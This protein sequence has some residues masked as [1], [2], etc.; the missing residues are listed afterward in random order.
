LRTEDG[1]VTWIAQAPFPPGDGW[2]DQ[3]ITVVD[4]QRAVAYQYGVI[5]STQDGGL[6]WVRSQM[7]SSV[8]VTE[9]G[10][11][12]GIGSYD[13]HKLPLGATE[14]QVVFRSGNER[15]VRTASMGSETDGLLVEY[16]WSTSTAVWNRTS[17]GGRTWSTFVPAGLP[18]E[19]PYWLKLTGSGHAWTAVNGT[20][21]RSVDAGASWATVALPADASYWSVSDVTIHDERTL[22]FPHETGYYLSTDAGAHWTLLQV[23]GDSDW[24]GE[25]RLWL[26]GGMQWLVRNDRVHVTTDMGM[27]WRQA[28]GPAADEVEGAMAAVWFF[29]A[30]KGM[31]VSS[32]G[33][34]LET[35]DGGRTWQRRALA[36]GSYTAPRLQFA[37]RSV[38][39]M[40]G[41]GGI[42]K[43][44]DGGASWWLPVT[45]TDMH[46]IS[47][48]HFAD[49]EHG[50]AIVNG[51]TVVQTVDGGGNWQEKFSSPYGM[52]AI[53]FIDSDVG[54]MVGSS[55]AI[56]RTV[57]G[58]ATW[59][60]RASDTT[61]QLL[62]VTFVDAQHGWAVGDD[63]AVVQTGDGGLSWQSVPVPQLFGRSSALRDVRFADRLHGWIVG[64]DG[65]MLAT[66]DGGQTWA[67]QDSGTSHSLHGAFALDPYTAWA[68]GESS[69]VLATVTAGQ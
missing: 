68:V 52:H 28:F 65:T 26:Q 32:A 69:T 40:S 62:R 18:S 22:G 42:S 2:S 15:Y 14:S 54:V 48:F 23:P 13:V 5:A 35:T 33:W 45:D 24:Y 8:T 21:F 37:S 55:G 58:G 67:L 34:L 36:T 39:W 12:W 6:T 29:D 60:L 53:H 11:A 16:E 7:W 10:T 27:S 56:M 20:L 66:R 38:G 9:H 1:G 3:R 59:S 43:T 51:Y 44:T 25:L 41:A 49:D 63:S 19:T 30:A 31:A 61:A 4:G 46:S 17:N 47:D 64:D 57:D 50:W